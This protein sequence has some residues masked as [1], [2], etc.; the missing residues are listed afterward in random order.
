MLPVYFSSKIFYI[1]FVI[2]F[3]RTIGGGGQLDVLVFGIIIVS[4]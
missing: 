1:L 3:R 4:N 2:E